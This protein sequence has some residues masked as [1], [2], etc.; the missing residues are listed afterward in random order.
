MLLFIGCFLLLPL[1][2]EF[3]RGPLLCGLYSYFLF[4]NHLAYEMV[5]LL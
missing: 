3:C 4:E 5:S 2:V 1:C